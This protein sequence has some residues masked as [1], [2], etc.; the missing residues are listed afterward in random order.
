MFVSLRKSSQLDSLSRM[1]S[2]RRPGQ[3]G[4]GKLRGGEAA[5]EEEREVLR[6]GVDL[7]ML[8]LQVQGLGALERERLKH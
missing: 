8:I 5:R 7:G 1:E 2:G 6:E 4:C 3:E